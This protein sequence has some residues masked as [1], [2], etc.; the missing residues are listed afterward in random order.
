VLSL[1]ILI[2]GT[3]L[4]GAGMAWFSIPAFLQPIHLA[5]ATITFGVQFMLLLVVIKNFK[6]AYT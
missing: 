1:I 4:V 5:L 6:T 2:L 3:I